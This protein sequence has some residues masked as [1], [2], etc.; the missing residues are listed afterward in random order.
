MEHKNI[1]LVED[2]YLDVIQV[3]RALNKLNANY[4]LHTAFNGKEA[5][6]MLRGDNPDAL[7]NLPDIILLDVN[8]PRMNG[9][10]FLQE[11]RNDNKLR[12]INVFIMTTSDDALDRSEAERLGVNGYIIKPL[13]FDDYG[14]KASSMDTFNLLL[15]LL[16]T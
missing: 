15:D 13:N 2:D 16:R 8:M 5:L 14:N 6:S 7:E 10:E 11:L 12:E 9:L 1:L 4:S 3:Q